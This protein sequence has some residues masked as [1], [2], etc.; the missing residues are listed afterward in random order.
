MVKDT[1]MHRLQPAWILLQWR[2]QGFKWIKGEGIEVYWY[3]TRNDYRFFHS[4]LPTSHIANNIVKLLISL[5][6][7]NLIYVI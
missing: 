3:V 4:W 2:T 7:W 1:H 6:Y 5:V